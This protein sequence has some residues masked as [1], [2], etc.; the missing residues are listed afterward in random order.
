MFTSKNS[1]WKF[2]S[3]RNSLTKRI[4][5]LNLDTIVLGRDGLIYPPNLWILSNTFKTTD[6]GNLIIADNQTDFYDRSSIDVKNQLA[7]SAWRQ[8]N[9]KEFYNV[10]S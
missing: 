3:G 4:S 6:Q 7:F 8:Y 1:V 9:N 5:K 2:E 10:V